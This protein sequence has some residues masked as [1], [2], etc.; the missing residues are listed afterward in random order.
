MFGEASTEMQDLPKELACI[1]SSL[2]QSF[3]GCLLCE[4]RLQEVSAWKNLPDS[5]MRRRKFWSC[6]LEETWINWQD[7]TERMYTA[8]LLSEI[9]STL[10]ART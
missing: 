10:R 2:P 9:K 7:A 5:L 3:L 4:M 1:A 6:E 8:G